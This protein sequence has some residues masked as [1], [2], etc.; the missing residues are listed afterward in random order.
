MRL[1]NDDAMVLIP[2]V[3][4][5]FEAIDTYTAE[6]GTYVAVAGGLSNFSD[7][8][9]CARMNDVYLEIDGIRY[10][11]VQTVMAALYE[12]METPVDY[13]GSGGHCIGSYE[14]SGTFVIFDVPTDVNEVLMSFGNARKQLIVDWM[15]SDTEQIQ[16]YEGIEH[17]LNA[18]YF[19]TK[20]L[21]SNSY[22]RVDL[23]INFDWGFGAPHRQLD[24]D[25]FSVRWTGWIQ[26][27]YSEPYTFVLTSDDGVQLWIN[28]E[29]IIADW[30]AHETETNQQTVQLEANRL[31]EIR[32]EYFEGTGNAEIQLM[33]LSP[34][35]PLEV[36][37]SLYLYPN[38][39]ELDV[40]VAAELEIVS[41]TTV[42]TAMASRSEQESV[43]V[44]WSGRIQ[45][46]QNV[47]VRANSSTSASVVTVVSPGEVV[48]ILGENATSD[49]FNIRTKKNHEGW[50]AS[51]LIQVDE[52]SIVQAQPS[53]G[54]SWVECTPNMRSLGGGFLLINSYE[55]E[56]YAGYSY[57]V[58]TR[59]TFEDYQTF[60]SMSEEWEGVV[61]P[62]TA[63][64]VEDFQGV[65]TIHG[66]PV[67]YGYDGTVGSDEGV[68]FS[69]EYGGLKYN[70]DVSI[71][72]FEASPS[73]RDLL[74]SDMQLFIA[75]IKQC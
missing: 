74:Y 73:V 59:T 63:T 68:F 21:V 35:Q 28:D 41:P 60:V 42:P 66:I 44:L 70:G 11:P 50:I 13:I 62:I 71:F 69:F 65:E 6:N 2:N 24:S 3:A 75:R 31:Y 55:D 23:N 19:T 16:P 57:R 64:L 36:I 20:S 8:R 9:Q 29:R 51:F 22:E 46:D 48:T 7:K 38:I 40:A 32:L 4:I 37:P 34:S 27:Q 72:G 15:A 25:N 61:F 18:E 54:A 1:L 39:D 14:D 56:D 30:Q 53:S 49:W 17:G 52:T 58:T 33:W 10:S 47:N 5:F 67:T 45:S 43:E 12:Q 26:P